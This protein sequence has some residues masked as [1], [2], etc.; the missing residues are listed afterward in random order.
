MAKGATEVPRRRRG[1]GTG[2]LPPRPQPPD[3]IIDNAVLREQVLELAPH[4]FC[5]VCGPLLPWGRSG[6]ARPLL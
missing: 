2:A 1:F 3:G 5:T 6:R 4:Y